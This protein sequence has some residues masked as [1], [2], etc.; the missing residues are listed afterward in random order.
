MEGLLLAGL[1]LACAATVT[2]WLQKRKA[3]AQANDTA[4]QLTAIKNRFQGIVDADAEAVRVRREAEEQK[5]RIA[6]DAL[7][8]A[9]EAEAR[10]RRALATLQRTEADLATLTTESQRLRD[11]LALLSEEAH[12]LDF[13]VYEPRFQF[14]DSSDYKARLSEV[15][16]EQKASIKDGRAAHTPSDWTV[17]GSAAKGKKMVRDRLKLMFR[18]FNGE[19][20]AAVARV[21]YNN[22]EV[23][24]RRMAN[25]FERVNK[26]SVTTG[27][28]IEPMYL[29]LKL[30]ELHLTH[31][32][33]EKRQAE[34]EEQRQIREQMREEMKA[35]KE[36]ERLQREAEKE[37]A[38][39][40]KALA[41]ARAEVADAAGAK[42]DKLRS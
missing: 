42:Q 16:R 23:M 40:E 12:L 10:E 29:R 14:P 15:R 34:R 8:A 25:A 33:H 38:R 18:A 32:Y 6:G 13:G 39:Y 11:E 22:V 24:E 30:D 9:D 35:K 20:D 3:D 41:K 31:E 5:E 27:C 17:N 1:I 4:Q 7:R 36:I 2:I 26:L 21:K 19:C 37:E 28:E